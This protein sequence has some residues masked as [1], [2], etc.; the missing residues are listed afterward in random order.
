[1]RRP[2]EV[3]AHITFRSE[4]GEAPPSTFGFRF[5]SLY[6]LNDK[7][8]AEIAVQVATALSTAEGTAALK[9]SIILREL[10][11]S[12]ETTGIFASVSDD[13]IARAEAD[14]ADT[15][16]PPPEDKAADGAQPVSEPGDVNAD[17]KRILSLV[18]RIPAAA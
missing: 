8:K 14:E 15:A 4:Y 12:S 13:D 5:A 18:P 2:L 3:I 6:G 9:P 10:K 1:M 16:A 17:P 7:E 11:R